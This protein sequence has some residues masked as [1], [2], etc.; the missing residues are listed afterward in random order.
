MKICK[1]DDIK[2]MGEKISFLMMDWDE[3]QDFENGSQISP[4]N[5]SVA[6]AMRAT[7][8]GGR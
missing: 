6:E 4:E 2:R 8:F 3:I 7:N 1:E 5:I